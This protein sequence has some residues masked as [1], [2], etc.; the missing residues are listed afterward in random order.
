MCV[1]TIYY[2]SILHYFTLFYTIS[3]IWFFP[4]CD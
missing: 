4:L 3:P 1:T 2:C